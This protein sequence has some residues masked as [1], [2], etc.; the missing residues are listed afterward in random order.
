MNKAVE[1]ILVWWF[2]YT[3]QINCGTSGEIS[4]MCW[5]KLESDEMKA[6]SSGNNEPGRMI[7]NSAK[8]NWK[9]F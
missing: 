9:Y 4:E 5:G 3:K 6:G 1:Q 8:L 7:R 2:S